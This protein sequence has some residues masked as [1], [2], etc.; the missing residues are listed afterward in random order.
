[1]LAGDVIT[2]VDLVA[3]AVFA[4]SGALAAAAQRNDIL[5]FVLFG[6]VVVAVFGEIAEFSGGLD[7]AG[8]IDTT[9]AG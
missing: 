4:I 5:A 1:M 9:Y 8:N 7:L 3:T 2:I 6:S